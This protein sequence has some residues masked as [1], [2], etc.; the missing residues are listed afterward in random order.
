M[1]RRQGGDATCRLCRA[2]YMTWRSPEA[3]RQTKVVSGTIRLTTEHP[4][5]GAIAAD[6]DQPRR[7]TDRDSRNACQESQLG[8]SGARSPSP[9]P[10]LSVTM[11]AIGMLLRRRPPARRRS[12]AGLLKVTVGW[13]RC[14][15]MPRAPRPSGGLIV[16]DL[17][18]PY[19]VPLEYRIRLVTCGS[20]GYQAA[21]A[22]S[23]I[24]PPTTG[25]RRIRSP[26]RSVTVMWPPSGTRWAMPWCG[27]AVL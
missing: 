2:A 26:S 10:A 6:A 20:S 15:S 7:R 14:L 11:S 23:L 17:A 8:G 27:R 1:H 13:P 18:R 19:A 12:V 9:Y 4:D 22:Y 16:P 21:R 25:F 5:L 24:R 3:A